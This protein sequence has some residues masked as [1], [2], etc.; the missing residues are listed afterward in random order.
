MRTA[1]LAIMVSATLGAVCL[2]GSSARPQTIAEGTFKISFFDVLDMPARIDEPRLR[3]KGDRYFISCAVANRSD[4]QLLGLRLVM[5]IV[6]ADG[7]LRT[8]LNWSEESAVAAASINA[9]ELYPPIKDKD[10]VQDTDRLFLAV[11]EAIGHE[12]IWRVVDTER[13]LRAFSR[14]QHDVLAKVRTVANKDDREIP[15]RVI[16]LEQER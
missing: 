14:G 7:K 2:L 8:R 9:F 3:K 16:P 6:T 11:D 1:R 13:I 10:K 12:T 15:A 4:E 5:M